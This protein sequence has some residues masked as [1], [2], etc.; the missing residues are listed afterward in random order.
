M[1]PKYVAMRETEPRVSSNQQ[2]RRETSR[3]IR[4]NED[5]GA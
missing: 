1:V 5:N 3:R 4:S 2:V